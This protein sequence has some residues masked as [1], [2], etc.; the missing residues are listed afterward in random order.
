[1]L[2]SGQSTQTG[3]TVKRAA[4]SINAGSGEGLRDAP[5]LGTGA[6]DKEP[7]GKEDVELKPPWD[8]LPYA[9]D[10]SAGTLPLLMRGG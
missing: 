3:V 5:K 1:M 8:L 2:S 6:R 4:S 7:R 9:P 10:V